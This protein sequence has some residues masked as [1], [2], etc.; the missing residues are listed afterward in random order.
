[1]KSIGK[2]SKK[3]TA[4]KLTGGM[5]VFIGT[6][7]GIAAKVLDTTGPAGAVLAVAARVTKKAGNVIQNKCIEN[8]IKY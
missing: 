2:S 1:M 5:M 7:L 8:R 4:A 3:K 6:A